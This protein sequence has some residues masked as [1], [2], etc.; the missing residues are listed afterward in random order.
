MLNPATGEELGRTPLSSAAEVDAA[1]RAAQAAFP[2][3]RRVLVTERVQYLF[4]LKGLLRW[5]P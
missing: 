3:W 4:R 5:A 2:G 1:A